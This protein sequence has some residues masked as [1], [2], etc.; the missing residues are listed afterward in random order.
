MPAAPFPATLT[1][2]ERL[3]T[4]TLQLSMQP[5]TDFD[6]VAGQ[7]LQLHIEI[8]GTVHKR[9][10]S[11]ANS[12]AD[13]QATGLLQVALSQVDG[14]VASTFFQHA[15]PGTRINMT[16]PYGALILP[17]TLPGQLILVGTGTGIAPYRSMI[18]QLAVLA[19]EGQAITTV[20]GFRY[21][22]ESIYAEDFAPVTRQRICLSRESELNSGEYAGHVQGQFDALNLN[23]EKDVVY[24]CGNPGMIDDCLA[25]L[26]D[27]GFSSRQIKR[28]K[29]VYS[30][31]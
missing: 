9:S 1:R 19:G 16:G 17:Q 2:I 6:F 15:T 20:M 18:P 25:Q 23:P 5:T 10:Y 13:F 4:N 21:R 28:E 7:F 31:H 11:I 26:K 3:S 14:G 24:L 22:H 27:M 8:D 12:P 30:G 29:Y